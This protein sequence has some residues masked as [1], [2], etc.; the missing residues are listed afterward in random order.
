MSLFKNILKPF[1]QFS[2][3][4]ETEDGLKESET[5][6][7]TAPGEKAQRLQNS[8][9]T[10][11]V[12]STPAPT[13]KSVESGPQKQTALNDYHT[14]FENLIEEANEKNPLFQGTDFK[15]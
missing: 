3:Q 8:E 6:Q 4:D 11:A 12:R 5:Q 14:Y 2:D 13:Y 9:Y 10:E 1:I 15:E 7:K